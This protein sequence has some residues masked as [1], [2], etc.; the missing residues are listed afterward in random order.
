MYFQR[1][2]TPKSQIKPTRRES[3]NRI[4]RNLC[5]AIA[6]MTCSTRSK[7][8]TQITITSLISITLMIRFIR[9]HNRCQIIVRLAS[10]ALMN[11]IGSRLK[12]G[13]FIS[14]IGISCVV[15]SI[16]C[17]DNTQIVTRLSLGSCMLFVGL[18]LSCYS[19]SREIWVSGMIC[20]NEFSRCL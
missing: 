18:C 6:L 17:N 10:S 5:R 2:L 15:C 13:R 12:S 11:S 20:C 1:F 16:G 19:V 14:Y 4:Q 3:H 8:R 9:S 7:D